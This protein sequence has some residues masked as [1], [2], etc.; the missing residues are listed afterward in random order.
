MNN[1]S[2][3]DPPGYI[4]E[5]DFVYE[6]E[7]NKF[8]F[9]C[10]NIEHQRF[11]NACAYLEKLKEIKKGKL[12]KNLDKELREAVHPNKFGTSMNLEAIVL[13]R[14]NWRG[15][16]RERYAKISGSMLC[17]YDVNEE[18]KYND[19]TP[20][21]FVNIKGSVIKGYD[22][23]AANT[24]KACDLYGLGFT[25]DEARRV[26]SIA[27]Q[28]KMPF[29]MILPTY[30]ERIEWLYSLKRKSELD[31]ND[32]VKIS[33]GGFFKE[34]AFDMLKNFRKRFEIEKENKVNNTLKK[35]F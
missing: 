6:Q 25:E 9:K 17:F 11:S 26:I 35:V 12:E 15:Q 33:G 30:E 20:R 29:F 3:E 34:M 1:N 24:N 2:I 21:S 32:K 28:D 13:K 7:K 22:G 4:R 27:S 5:D 19:K 14:S 10:H 23:K 18:K 31:D 16:L 8:N